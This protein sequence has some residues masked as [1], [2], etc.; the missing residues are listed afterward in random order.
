MKYRLTYA[1]PR[2]GSENPTMVVYEKKE[3]VIEADTATEAQGACDR[4]L[5]QGAVTCGSMTY[6]R[7]KVTF[8]PLLAPLRRNSN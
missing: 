5:R 7:T 4:F 1:Q 6:V 8:I 2:P 3:H